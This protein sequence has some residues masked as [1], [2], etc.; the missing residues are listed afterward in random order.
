MLCT[1]VAM[2]LCKMVTSAHIYIVHE[3]CPM[4]WRSQQN[5]REIKPIK[6]LTL[7][8]VHQAM[9]DH[10]VQERSGGIPLVAETIHHSHYRNGGRK[11]EVNENFAT[12]LLMMARF[13]Q[14]LIDSKFF[15]F[16]YK[17]FRPYQLSLL[18]TIFY[19]NPHASKL[20]YFSKQLLLSSSLQ[21]RIRAIILSLW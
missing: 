13:M 2:I 14:L 10:G 19:F 5:C 17:P 3:E 16:E 7:N 15:H 20:I 9:T 21:Y 1:N 6:N 4:C 18:N 12:P 11:V 8:I